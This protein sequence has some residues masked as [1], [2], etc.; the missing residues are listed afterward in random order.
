M[1]YFN[2]HLKHKKYIQNSQNRA[3]ALQRMERKPGIT[4]TPW[5]TN[6]GTVLLML[7]TAFKRN[8]CCRLTL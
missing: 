6:E 1:N 2:N 4:F 8:Y 3:S 5:Q 7:S